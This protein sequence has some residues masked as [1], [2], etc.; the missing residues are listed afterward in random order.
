VVNEAPPAPVVFESALK[1]W[2][3]AVA[4]FLLFF[5][6]AAIISFLLHWD[7]AYAL[8]FAF[9]WSLF[10]APLFIWPN[11]VTMY[12]VWPDCVRL[13]RPTWST[14]VP[15]ADVRGFYR[16]PP[17]LLDRA[18]C[19]LVGAP[20]SSLVRPSDRIR[21]FWGGPN[22]LW[23]KDAE[24]FVR[25]ANAAQAAWVRDPAAMFELRRS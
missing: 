19:W 18:R 4:M 16:S 20:E 14:E 22:L 15:Y 10:M 11:V 9:F 24:A 5:A 23:P 6:V 17:G 8:S 7:S 21:N 12:E 2:R 3:V 13:V 1:P 25:A